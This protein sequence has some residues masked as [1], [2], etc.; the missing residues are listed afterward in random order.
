MGVD[1]GAIY[2]KAFRYAFSANR[3]L[4][5]FVIN[6]VIWLTLLF[7]AQSIINAFA[8]GDSYRAV[9][10][11]I[12]A[13]GIFFLLIIVL[14]FIGV[15]FTIAY[16]HNAFNFYKGK[17]EKLS[18]SYGYAKS[19]YL[20]FLGGAIIAG[21]IVLAIAILFSA[22]GSTIILINYSA[23]FFYRLVIENFAT[24]FLTFIFM[25]YAPILALDSKG[26]V[27]SMKAS[28]NTSMKNKGDVIIYWI[29]L[30]FIWIFFILITLIPLAIGALIVG[31]GASTGGFMAAMQ[32]NMLT[33]AL[34]TL[35]F[36]LII[37]YTEVFRIAAMTNLYAELKKGRR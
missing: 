37:S 8:T 9:F 31:I 7:S 17:N 5:M 22:V 20:K 29:L 32:S 36:A 10:G 13:M 21:V 4:P 26:I 25:V 2:G 27:D 23:G 3:L 16:I 34:L 15:F 18:A 19:K 6:S 1:F 35:L 30:I 12:G 14:S 24:L 11:L 33:L 28:Y